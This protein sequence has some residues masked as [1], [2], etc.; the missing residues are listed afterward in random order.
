MKD[1]II[2][3][4]V[5][6]LIVLAVFIYSDNE[7]NSGQYAKLSKMKTRVNCNKTYRQEHGLDCVPYEELE[8]RI[9]RFSEDRII[10]RNEFA[11]IELDLADIIDNLE[12]EKFLKNIKD[13]E[14]IKR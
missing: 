14:L 4:T 2:V 11:I 9:T 12:K 13:T 7:I 1:I 10:T 8:A 3:V 6:A 5:F